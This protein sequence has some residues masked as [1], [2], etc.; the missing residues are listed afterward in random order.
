[1]NSDSELLKEALAC[2]RRGW[3]VVPVAPGGKSPIVPW[4]KYSNERASPKQ[5]REWWHTF[6]NANIGV[7]TGKISG[8]VVIDVDRRGRKMLSRLPY[9]PLQVET[10]KGNFHLYYQH[11]GGVVPN[12]VN[13]DNLGIDIRGDGG[14][15]VV[16]P[17]IHETGR[18]YRWKRKK[19]RSPLPFPPMDIVRTERTK[20]VN[21][22]EHKDNDSWISEILLGVTHGGRNDAATRLAGYYFK[23]GMPVDLVQTQMELWNTRNDPPLSV[24]EISTVVQSIHKKNLQALTK[25][26]SAPVPDVDSNGEAIT[27]PFSLMTLDSY[28][29]RFGDEEVS[30]TV[31]DWLPN[32]TIGMLVASPGSYKTWLELDLAIS[33]ASGRPFLGTF[34]VK[35][36][37]PVIIVQQE[38]FHG[39]MA[40]RM[41]LMTFLKTQD[42][43]HGLDEGMGDQRHFEATL[44]PSLPVYLHPDRRLRFGDSVVLEELEEKIKQIRPVLVILD[45]LYSTGDTDDYLAKTVSQMFV[46]KNLRDRYGCSFLIAH[47]TAKNSGGNGKD[48]KPSEPSRDQSWGSQFVNAFL[49]SGWQIRKIA[50]KVLQV[51]RHFKVSED[52]PD[53]FLTMNISTKPPYSY[54]IESRTTLEQQ[55]NE[56]RKRKAEVDLLDLFENRKSI[57]IKEM[58]QK[59][60]QHRSTTLRRAERLVTERV[61][62][63]NEDGTYSI[64]TQGLW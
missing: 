55:E 27:D 62:T 31:D 2:C 60:G 52:R 46:L 11:P 21:Q 51:K 34:A 3:S 61:L 6:P 15:V 48:G 54:T 37:G 42:L 57:G 28:M 1:M 16:P 43:D 9:T 56:D 35:R 30:W 47:H 24:R 25:K 8:L 38:D 50:D 59:L 49:E 5:I 32:N 19:L 13:K 33:V 18:V 64:M 4:T 22:S 45:P 58:A 14:L 29:E 44:P 40:E 63:K 36:T 12:A 26:G 41:G 53:V 10:R 20:E 17:S 7:V 39:S 23:K